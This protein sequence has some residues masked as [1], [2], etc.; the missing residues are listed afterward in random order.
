MKE[1][2]YPYYGK[3]SAP[4]YMWLAARLFGEL[5]VT[6]GEFKFYIFRGNLWVTRS[7]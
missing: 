6:E 2:V 4:W 5:L 1:R 7:H 3:N